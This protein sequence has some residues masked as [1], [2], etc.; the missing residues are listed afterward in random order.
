M[1]SYYVF[2]HVDITISYHDGQAEDWG[3]YL[4]GQAV[5]GRIV[6]VKLTPRR[7]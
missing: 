3:K 4:A 5:G 1:F 6:S 2:N 7:Y